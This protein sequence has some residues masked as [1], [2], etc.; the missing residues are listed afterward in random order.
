[1]YG[2]ALVYGD[3]KK[4][5]I[6]IISLKYNIT[7]LDAY[8]QIGCEFHSKED[9]DKFTNKEI[10]SMDGKEALKWW[11]IHKSLILGIYNANR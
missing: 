2:N 10:L 9:W 5:P 8:I 7:I 3:A 1:V 11:K 6:N 4:S